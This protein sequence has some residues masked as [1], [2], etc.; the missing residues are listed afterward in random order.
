MG[1]LPGG[2]LLFSLMVSVIITAYVIPPSTLGKDLIT[3]RDVTAYWMIFGIGG[4]MFLNLLLV[5]HYWCKWVCPYPLW[6]H[7][8]KT[9]DTLKVVFD[10]KR[11]GVYRM[12]PLREF[13][14]YRY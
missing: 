2:I 10:H 12:Q 1:F 5:R 6:Q 9:D 14:F 3:G 13:L 4:V 8:F 7:M 11:R